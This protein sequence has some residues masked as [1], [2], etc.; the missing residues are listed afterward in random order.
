MPDFLNINQVLQN[1]DLAEDMS[2]AEFG[3]GSADFSLAL[4]KKL[5][6][7]KVCALDIQEEKLSALKS[8]LALQR[9]GNVTTMLCDLEVPDGSTL[10]ESSQDVVLIPNVLFQAENKR[11]IISESKRVLKSG[12][13]LL[14][15][16]WVANAPFGP[17]TGT[18]SPDEMK[19]MTI[20]SGFSLKK[21]FMAG[22]YHYAL[23][24]VK[25]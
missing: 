20:D 6:K 9:L 19:K 7:G 3:C 24:F 13:Q 17:K 16:D 25:P 1:L 15:V 21:E 11:G 12:G 18:V 5:T 2:A 14:T 23:I 22:D 4:A 8:K 10:P